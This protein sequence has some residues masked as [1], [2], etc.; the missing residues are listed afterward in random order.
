M[1]IGGCMDGWTDGVIWCTDS[2][3][4]CPLSSIN[5]GSPLR[6]HCFLCPDTI[7]NYLQ[8][9]WI[10]HTVAPLLLSSQRR[11]LIHASVEMI[12]RV[13]IKPPRAYLV[14]A[15][16]GWA[17]CKLY[18]DVCNG[19]QMR[20]LHIFNRH[21]AYSQK[22]SFN[23]KCHEEFQTDIEWVAGFGN[24][25]WKISWWTGILTGI[26]SKSLR[27]GSS[28]SLIKSGNGIVL[29]WLWLVLYAVVY[30][31]IHFTRIY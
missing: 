18:V 1:K 13:F 29:F 23:E 17:S 24:I 11:N 21:L 14:G 28:F 10:S 25:I 26:L 27:K 19:P 12:R 5:T 4:V 20:H 16:F 31:S 30:K 3:R 9:Q 2:F 7:Y 8:V 15:V 6:S 22:P